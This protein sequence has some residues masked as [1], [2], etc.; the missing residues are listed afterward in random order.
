M[1]LALYGKPAS[2]IPVAIGTDR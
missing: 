1:Y 2:A